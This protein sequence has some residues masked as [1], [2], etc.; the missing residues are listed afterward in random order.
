MP[1]RTIPHFSILGGSAWT[2]DELE[3]LAAGSD[4]IPVT[5][6]G[7]PAG[8]AT[9]LRVATDGEQLF[10][11]FRHVPLALARKFPSLK[12]IETDVAT[13]GSHIGE[14]RLFT[15]KNKDQAT[16][17]AHDSA[18]AEAVKQYDYAPSRIGGILVEQGPYHDQDRWADVP[19]QGDDDMAGK[20]LATYEGSVGEEVMR[21]VTQY[22]AAHPSVDYDTAMKTVLNVDPLL[23][24]AYTRVPWT[25]PPHGGAP[26]V[27]PIDAGTFQAAQAEVDR[28]ARAR[29]AKY[30]EDYEIAM[31]QVLASDDELRKRYLGRL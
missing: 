15:S 11:D 13:D 21:R 24:E 5:V 16:V 1:H 30:N 20:V 27:D 7:E 10:A 29:M 4:E 22:Q 28:Q 19:E 23:K 14:V 2:E 18:S 3:A 25:I 9:A 31:R 12:R 26:Q 17:R 8:V 6:D